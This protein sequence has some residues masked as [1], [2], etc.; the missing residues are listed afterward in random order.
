M[1]GFSGSPRKSLQTDTHNWRIRIL[2]NNNRRCREPQLA[3]Y[4]TAA[5]SEGKT[6]TTVSEPNRKPGRCRGTRVNAGRKTARAADPGMTRNARKNKKKGYR[7]DIKII[8]NEKKKKKDETR[9]GVYGFMA[10]GTAADPVWWMDVTMVRV[11]TGRHCT[12]RWKKKKTR[13]NA[14]DERR[15]F[16]RRRRDGL[17]TTSGSQGCRLRPVHSI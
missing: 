13:L 1:I 5:G 9:T 12:W 14:I 3:P 15:L 10:S 7:Y 11:S 4:R 6:R 16:G 17:N 8:S 2:V